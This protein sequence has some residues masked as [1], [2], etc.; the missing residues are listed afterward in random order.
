MPFVPDI[1]SALV[2]A[3]VAAMIVDRDGVVTWANQACATLLAEPDPDALRLS[4]FYVRFGED[5]AETLRKVFDHFFASPVDMREPWTRQFVANGADGSRPVVAATLTPV[6][7]EDG[8]RA[9]VYLRNLTREATAE[10]RFTQ[11]FE[12]MPLGAV[13]VDGHGCIAQANAVLASQF[14]WSIEAMIGQPLSMLLPERYHEAHAQELAAFVARPYA[15]ILGLDRDLT[16]LHCSGREF[17]VEI[18][19]TRLETIG[20]PLF[21]AIVSDVSHRR[22]AER[23]LQQTNAQLEEFTYVASHDLRS[24]LRG[25]GDLVSW[26]RE[27]LGEALGAQAIPPEVAH[28]FDRITQRI[29]RCEQMIDDLLHYARAGVRDPDLHQLDPRELVE[30]ALAMTAIPEGFVVELD[31]HGAP[32]TAP[33]APLATSLRNLIANAVK[34]HGGPRGSIRIS[35]RD[36]GRFCVFTVEDDGQGIPTGSE[37]RIFKLFHRASPGTDGDGVGLALTRRMINAHGGMVTVQA[38]GPLG[39]A[40]FEVHWPRI[41]LLEGEDD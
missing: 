16:A 31:V 8:S 4:L 29:E 21:M 40:R 38:K 23:A 17:P 19:L 1:R 37:D 5:D 35:A 26:I 25:I 9:V 32:L 27:D 36:E 33:R 39:G 12:S 11:M 41:L 14:G 2:H 24:P 18:A 3:P 15:R 10:R 13:V 20:Q 34:H 6:A 22:R 7:D 28:N 30:E